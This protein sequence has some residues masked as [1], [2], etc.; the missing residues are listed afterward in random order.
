[1]G[2]LIYATNCSLDLYT[3]DQNGSFDWSVPTAEIHHYFNDLIRDVD[4][5]LYGRGMY[6]TMVFWES[7]DLEGEDEE[8][9]E[10]AQLWRD[11][12]KIVFSNSLEQVSSERTRIEAEFDPQSVRQ[13]KESS[14][15]DAM[16][17]GPTIAASAFAEGLIDAVE[18]VLYP[19]TIGGG[20]PAL[21]AGVE[22]E[23]V[24]ERRFENG[25]VH[26]SYEVKR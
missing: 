4:T 25:A 11:S 26:L 15:G 22:L 16:I 12:D 6:D 9:V 7:A 14:A 24:N 1:M 10:F 2:R 13:L 3:E 20:K 19:L 18:L 17:G 21:P 5:H 23:L 8:F